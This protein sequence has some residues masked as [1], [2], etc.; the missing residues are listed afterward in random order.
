MDGVTVASDPDPADTDFAGW[1]S[2][3]WTA[4]QRLAARLVPVAERD[5]LLQE[6]LLR[7]AEV[8][9]L[10]R[11]PRDPAELA[12]GHHRGPGAP[13]LDPAGPCSDRRCRG[14]ATHR[15]PRSGPG[16]APR[17]RR[18]QRPLMSRPGRKQSSTGCSRGAEG[19]DFIG[20]SCRPNATPDRGS[21]VPPSS[22]CSGWRGD[23]GWQRRK[24]DHLRLR[25]AREPGHP[26]DAPVVRPG[27]SQLR[28]WRW[29]R[30]SGSL[31]R[32]LRSRGVV[33]DRATGSFLRTG[34]HCVRILVRLA[35]PAGRR[36]PGPWCRSL[37]RPVRKPFLRRGIRPP[38]S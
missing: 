2:P 18:P 20:V 32:S 7:L 38:R 21:P 31:S 14:G 15:G 13:D 22:G 12:A 1:V 5:D 36:H 6:S 4:M 34:V 17:R 27:W 33:D 8:A 10:R 30:P 29:P 24:N 16:P 19:R 25:R 23:G 28:W 11:R 26:M 35:S 37:H 3:H 9:H